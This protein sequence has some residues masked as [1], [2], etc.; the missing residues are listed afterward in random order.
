MQISVEIT[1]SLTSAYVGNRSQKNITA[2]LT[3]A[4]VKNDD[5][6]QIFDYVF[7]KSIVYLTILMVVP[8]LL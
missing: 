7:M 2:G 3:S 1:L 8:N 6:D 4:V 5:F